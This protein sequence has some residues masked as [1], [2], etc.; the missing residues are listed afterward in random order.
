MKI[1]LTVEVLVRVS[2]LFIQM[3]DLV[4]VHITLAFTVEVLLTP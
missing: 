4:F 1:F 3:Y 2:M